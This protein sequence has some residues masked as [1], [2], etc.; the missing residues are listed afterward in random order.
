MME[1]RDIFTRARRRREFFIR[2][3]LSISAIAAFCAA[4]FFE[5]IQSQKKG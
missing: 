4:I 2:V 3:A 1:D 5:Y